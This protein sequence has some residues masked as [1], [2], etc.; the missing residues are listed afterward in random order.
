[1]QGYIIGVIH[2][3]MQHFA[4]LSEEAEQLFQITLFLPVSI[5]HTSSTPNTLIQEPM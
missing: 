5:L 4:P 3:T 2:I 1:M